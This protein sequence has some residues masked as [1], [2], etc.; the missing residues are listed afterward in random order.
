MTAQ[1]LYRPLPFL[2]PVQPYAI[3]PGRTLAE[4]AAAVPELPPDFAE[5]GSICINGQPVPAEWWGRIRPR[6]DAGDCIV[7][8]HVPLQDSGTLRTVASIAVLVASVAVSGGALGPLAAL[9]IGGISGAALAGGA[10][11][12]GGALAIAALI[13]PPSTAAAAAAASP[14]SFNQGAASLSGNVLAKG[15]PLPR[16]C[17]TRKVFPPLIVQPLVYNIGDDQYVLGVYGL[18]GPTKL[19]D[20]RLDGA[21]LA[22]LSEVTVETR[23]G[24]NT[25]A[26]LTL[27]DYQPV[28]RSLA[29]EVS[30]HVL[31]A[32]TSNPPGGFGPGGYGSCQLADQSTP[33]NSLPTWQTFSTKDSPDQVL[34][35]LQFPEGL[36]YDLS[37]VQVATPIR[38]R[39]RPRGGGSWINLPEVHVV[40][41]KVG[42]FQRTIKLLFGSTVPGTLPTPVTFNDNGFWLAYKV[43]PGQAGG[44]GISPATAGW[45]ADAAF[46]TGAGNDVYSSTTAATTKVTNVAFYTDRCEF[47]LPPATFPQ[48]FWDIQIMQGQAYFAYPTNFVPANY[49]TVTWGAA[50]VSDF[51]Y[52]V[53]AGGFYLIGEDAAHAR[54]RMVI[55]R[56]TDI[57]DGDPC[58]A[59]DMAKI[60]ILAKNRAIGQLS[61]L[62]SGYTKDWNGAAWA[63]DT[64]TSNPA[65]HFRDVLTGGLTK[66][67][68]PTAIIDSPALVAWRADNIARGLEVNVVFEGKSMF[69]CMTVLAAAGMARPRQSE[70][71]DV[72]VDKD[73]SAEAVVQIFSPLNSRGFRFE[74]GFPDLP[75][76]LRVTIA[77]AAQDYATN[78]FDVADPLGAAGDVYQTISYDALTD[79]TLATDRAVFDLMQARLR[80]AF[81]SL[82]VSTEHLFSRRGDLVGVQHDVLVQMAGFA[83]IKSIVRSGGFITS[84]TLA[85]TIRT[86]TDTYTPAAIGISVRLTDGTVWTKATTVNPA[87]GEVTLITFGAGVAADPGSTLL[88]VDCLAATGETGSTYSR[89]LVFSVLPNKS[90]INLADVVLVDEAPSLF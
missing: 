35:S 81:F 67:P 63:T 31:N 85:G 82:Q 74:K 76:G 37:A 15:R 77:D 6:P 10:I 13:P 55:D 54:Y 1:I 59:T 2:G 80:M 56:V 45:T 86:K 58:P 25:D 21:E 84:I 27:I 50:L 34:I 53:S 48:G 5:I 64:I 42:S 40:S 17:G 75:D 71:W 18:A 22:S 66:R 79:V 72:L 70:V 12:I 36:S 52:Y 16:V 41:K 4:I 44:G 33:A 88:D 73:R 90:D 19:E 11:G 43:V 38:I 62:A 68:I 23:E 78:E 39:M 46:S 9:S 32:N 51:F 24:W 49:T 26:P 60:A 8:L 28:T 69:E 30:R 29:L 57:W 89:M 65:P 20:I 47:F 61:V 3:E 14:D 83:L 7:T 87:A